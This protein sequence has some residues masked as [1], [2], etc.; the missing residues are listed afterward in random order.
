MRKMSARSLRSLVV[1]YEIW[2]GNKKAITCNKS[3]K[4]MYQNTFP[5]QIKGEHPDPSPDGSL[6]SIALPPPDHLTYVTSLR[7]IVLFKTQN[8]KIFGSLAPLARNNL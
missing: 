8:A 5:A 4:N 7:R 3:C 1:I 6:C 2:D